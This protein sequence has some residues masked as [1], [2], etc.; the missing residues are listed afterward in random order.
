MLSVIGDV[1]TKFVIVA[2][3]A[4]A[5][6]LLVEAV[7]LL[8]FTG[9][10][11]RDRVNRR[12][13]ILLDK[14]DREKALVTLRRE[15]GL[16]GEGLYLIPAKAFNRLV[17]QSGTTLG[18]YK[19]VGIM[20]ALFVLAFVAV[21]VVRREPFEAIAAAPALGLALPL[22]VLRY[23]RN[24]RKAKFGK[25]FPDAIDIIVRSLRA[26]HPVPIAI[27]MVARE[28]ADPVGSE[29]GMLADEVTYGSDLE[30]AMRNLYFRVGQEDLP[31]FV[32]A[33][34]IQGA[35]GGNLSEI[36][37]NLSRV[38]R[39]RFK[40]RR[41]IK[42]LSSEGR[43]S[44]LALTAMPILFFGAISLMSPGFYGDIMHYRVTQIALGCC[45]GWML[46]GNL[47]MRRMINFKI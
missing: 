22:W 13:R 5:V 30:T 25:Q 7:Y 17:L 44:A 2:C 26:G 11:Y 16:T 23:L 20:A 10:T 8:V 3:V 38:I 45:L 12:L 29:F 35:T 46:I 4:I 19:V 32:T 42:A 6:V 39:E 1:N 43:F 24:R 27:S 34:A 18:I 31:L 33:V 37:G 40:M 14:P 9:E 15:R 36:L 28:M 21:L 41:K 47:I